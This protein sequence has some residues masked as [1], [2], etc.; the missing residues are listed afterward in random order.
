M[1]KHKPL[2]EG[3]ATLLIPIDKLAETILLLPRIYHII[4]SVES[5][6][7]KTVALRVKSE[8]IFGVNVIVSPEIIDVGSTRT[9]SIIPTGRN[10]LPAPPRKQP[11]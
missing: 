11:L 9:M 3:E 2:N 7:G 8:D 10:G 1:S 4:G 5:V 6:D